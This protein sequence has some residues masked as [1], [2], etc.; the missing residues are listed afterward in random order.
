M[1]RMLQDYATTSI[2]VAIDHLAYNQRSIQM[3]SDD[4]CS[5]HCRGREREEVIIKERGKNMYPCRLQ[6]IVMVYVNNKLVIY[7]KLPNVVTVL[8]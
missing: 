5:A 7:R 1:I 8:K 3:N 4:E 2:Q 6:I